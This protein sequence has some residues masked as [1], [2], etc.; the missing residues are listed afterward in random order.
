M[1]TS[2]RASVEDVLSE[3]DRVDVS[4]SDVE[5]LLGDAHLLV[6]DRI[7]DRGLSEQR[8]TR[9][10]TLVTCHMAVHESSGATTG[11]VVEEKEA[12]NV[13]KRYNV[14]AAIG[15]ASGALTTF[16]NRACALDPTGQLDDPGEFF[17]VT[18]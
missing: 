14:D 10:E 11:G 16:W 5:P 18:L 15:E 3:L 17:T 1:T 12:G 7:G 13:R 4:V 6:E 2:P 8:L 9:I